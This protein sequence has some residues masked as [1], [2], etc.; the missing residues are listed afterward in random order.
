[1][2]FLTDDADKNNKAGFSANSN[3]NVWK[4]VK[5]QVGIIQFL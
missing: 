1:M 4:S 2:G 5:F 3:L